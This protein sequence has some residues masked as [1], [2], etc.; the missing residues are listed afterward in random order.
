[1]AENKKPSQE[2]V[3]LIDL[4]EKKLTIPAY[5][6][7]YKW[8]EKNVITLL[9]DIFEFVILKNKNYRLG[10]VILHEEGDDKHIVD[11]QQRLTT[12]SILLRCLSNQFNG[13]LLK[14]NFKHKIS[15]NNIVY[16]QRIINQWIGTKLR[17]DENKKEFYSKI[18]NKCEFIIFTVYHQDEAFQLFDSQN[19]RGLALEPFDL[20][21]AFHLR[22]MVYDTE[23]ERTICV[24]RWEKS[25]DNKTLKPILG[26]H[27]F[28]I[29]KWSKNQSKYSFTKD[30]ID[31]FK[32]ISLYQ[33]QR[34]PYESPVRM[35]DGLVDNSQNNKFLRN[36]H[37]AQ[38]Y[39]FSITMPIINGKRF[40]EYVDFYIQQREKLFDLD[41]E[42]LI[43]AE[44]PEFV[45][46]YEKNCLRY[47]GSSR[48]G[49]EKVRNMYENILFAFIDKFGYIDDFG[50]YY[51]AFYKT[52]YFIRCNKKRI[53]TETILNCDEQKIFRIINDAV[54]PDVLKSFQYKSYRIT[55]DLVKGIDNIKTFIEN[56]K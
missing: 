35:L 7:P 3:K 24:E 22:E 26:N 54:T 9:D 6:R 27:L 23:E 43:K 15:K 19:S 52:V 38:Y 40:F 36:L 1:M 10:S 21:K 33:K 51:K 11:G 41:K 42:D 48:S 12:I 18:L 8:T 34:Y 56:G 53:T 5:Q 47:S 31:E 29:R 37:I 50:S 39:P 55:G 44:I 45:E 13:L 30:D 49:D 20:L 16:N 2:S 14:Q 32:G 17:A 28:R 25:I 4:I 46:F